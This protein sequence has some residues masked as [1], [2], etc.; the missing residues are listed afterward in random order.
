MADTTLVDLTRLDG[1]IFDLDGVITLTASVHAAAWA[2]VFDEF[3]R[4]RAE[5][6]GAAF[7]R[8][9]PEDYRR[10]VDGRPRYDGVAAFLASRGIDLPRGDPADPPEAE[11]ICG[12]GNRKNVQFRKVLDTDG[13][14]VAPGVAALLRRL[15]QRGLRLA[16]VSGSRNARHVL[17]AAGLTEAFD[18]IL[19]GADAARRGLAGKPAPATF[20][21]AA[22]EIG[23]LPARAMVLEDAASG[24]E[25]GR[26]GGFGLVVGVGGSERVQE[27]RRAGADV[28][29]PG[30][31]A[32]AFG[33]DT[34]DL[35]PMPTRRDAV[36]AHVAGRRPAVML[37]DDGALAAIAAGAGLGT[38]PERMRTSMRRLSRRCSVAVVSGR[39][40]ADLERL[41]GIDSLVY[42]GSHGSDIA[43]PGGL[44]IK[45]GEAAEE[46]RMLDRAAA[47][48]QAA[49][50]PVEGA[51]VERRWLAVAVDV[52]QVAPVAMARV[53]DEV[54]RVVAEVA[55]LVTRRGTLI[56]LRFDAARDKGR[57]VMR[58][59][60]AMQLDRPEVLPIY[61][62]GDV[63][64]EAAFR[65]LATRGIG[66]VVGLEGRITAAHYRLEGARDVE[67][68]LETLAEILESRN[69]EG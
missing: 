56:E 65:V 33:R 50:A 7:R 37:G 14:T 19:D 67:R 23:I 52:R 64:D 38:L 58:I 6:G 1:A 21:A 10:H 49:L 27:L 12:I 28:V 40:R 24:V 60:E 45:E 39:D 66:I 63:T 44:R 36:A 29:V 57:A 59:L 32:L 18:T 9:T 5:A 15:R 68:L 11:T 48:L 69:E 31:G 17:A 4:R 34:T 8:F 30:L 3:L 26:G 47:Q 54:E 20:L 62:G 2:R 51:T 46:A 35:P 16:L 61:I 53:E 41:V 22:R 42:A 55:G 43:G 13:V 25:A